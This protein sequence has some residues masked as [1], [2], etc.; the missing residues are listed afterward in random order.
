MDAEVARL[1]QQIKQALLK[2]PDQ[3]ADLAQ[4]GSTFRVSLD[5]LL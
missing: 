5:G 2:N 1:C 3:S 4:L